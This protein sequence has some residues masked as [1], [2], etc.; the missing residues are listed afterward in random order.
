MRSIWECL[1][2]HEYVEAGI[3]VWGI[4]NVQPNLFVEDGSLFVTAEKYVN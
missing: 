1:K 4:N 3:P 2:K